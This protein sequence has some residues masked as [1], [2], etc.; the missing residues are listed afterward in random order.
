MAN[1]KYWPYYLAFLL[2][3]AFVV[4][5]GLV[6]ALFFGGMVDRPEN[7]DKGDNV[8]SQFGS[9]DR[10]H[11]V[12]LSS[13]SQVNKPVPSPKMM[14]RDCSQLRLNGQ[15]DSGV[16][17]IQPD[18]NEESFDAYCDMTSDGGGWTV[19]Q[20]RGV[21]PMLPKDQ[22]EDF[23]R[24]WADYEAGFG[25]VSSDYWLGLKR[26]ASLTKGCNHELLVNMT[27]WDN[28]SEYAR[29]GSFSISRREDSYRLKV[30][31]YS[32]T[33]SEALLHH[34]G[35]QFTTFDRQNDLNGKDNCAQVYKGAWWHRACYWSNLNG[36]Y[37][38]DGAHGVM[39]T[40]SG[41]EWGSRYRYSYMQTE[42]KIRSKCY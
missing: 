17:T 24:G 1:S 28:V 7:I 20:R 36:E 14:M 38:G 25:S 35:M 37:A 5:F 9:F 42:M 39:S 16:Y 31:N 11:D 4:G 6:F 41:M 18:L 40:R 33:A 13:S 8:E 19:F 29:Y 21:N 22:R 3:S 12:I 26:L 10:S 34:N 32:G 23:Y 30:G 2:V 15:N 27:A